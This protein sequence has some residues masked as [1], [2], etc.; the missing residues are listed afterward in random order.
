MTAKLLPGHKSAAPKKGRPAYGFLLLD[1]PSDHEIEGNIVTECQAIRA[2]LHNRGLGAMAK[3]ITATTTD[4]LE[5]VRAQ[6]YSRLGFV[7]VAAHAS[8]KGIALIG[9][10]RAGV[11]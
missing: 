4:G 9:D 5:K 10:A 1:L 11:S 7:H 8:R 3:I 6:R 2:I